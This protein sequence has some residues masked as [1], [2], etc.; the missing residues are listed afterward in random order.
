M[1]AP[2]ETLCTEDNQR[3]AA[4]KSSPEDVKA[5]FL[6]FLD[7]EPESEMVV[8]AAL[9]LRR[10]QFIA[11]VIGS[12]EFRDVTLL[13]L[14]SG[15]SRPVNADL[16]FALIKAWAA[17][18]PLSR[19]GTEAVGRAGSWHLLRWSVL[20]DP[21]FRAYLGE[22]GT[23]LEGLEG[24]EPPEPMMTSREEVGHV[25]LLLLGREPET[26][27]MA[28]S[29]L[30]AR[31][32]TF[33]STVLGSKEFDLAVLGP[34]LDGEPGR[35]PS[36][37]APSRALKAWTE[38]LPL[39]AETRD[40]VSG[41]ASWP[42]LRH[43]VFTD[44]VFQSA[45]DR[46]K[47]FLAG[48]ERVAPFQ[49]PVVSC[50]DVVAL[51]GLLLGRAPREGIAEAAEGEARWPFI[52]DM[53]NSKEFD[54]RVRDPMIARLPV[55]GPLFEAQ[56]SP[57]LASWAAGLAGS[58]QAR[59]SIAGA[60]GWFDLH[61]TLFAD[62]VFRARV[63]AAAAR[64][65]ALEG[66]LPPV[67]LASRDDVV[68]SYICLLGREPES[69]A[70]IVAAVG[71]ELIKILADKINS[72]EFEHRVRRPMLAGQAVSGVLFD[73]P[74]SVALKQWA[75]GLYVS[76][77]KAAAIETTQSWYQL[78]VA[79]LGD[80][81]FQSVVS[82]AASQLSGLAEALPPSSV[83]P[84]RKEIPENI[85]VSFPIT[86]RFWD[87][88][89]W[90]DREQPQVSIVILSY[91]RPDLA[92]NL[93]RSIWLFSAGYK[94]EVILVDNGSPAGE[95]RLSRDVEERTT[96]VRLNR[97]QYLGDAYNIG[98]ERAKAAFLVL[99]NND[100][101]VEPD[102][103]APL[104]G[105]LDTDQTVGAIGPKFLYPTGQLQ[106]AGALIDSSGY[107]VQ[108][109]KRGDPEAAEF[110][111]VREV[112][113][114]TGATIAMRRDDYLDLQGYDW[115][116]SPGYYEDVDL[117]FKLRARG[118]RIL[119]TP[120]SSVFHIESATMSERPPSA[121]LSIAV[122]N[123]RRRFV[124]KWRTLLEDGEASRLD[125]N[126]YGAGLARY[127]MVT[128]PSAGDRARVAVYFP[129][130]LIPGGG[131]K[132]ALSIVEQLAGAAEVY[133]VFE[134]EESVLRVISVLEDLGFPGLAFHAVTLKQAIAMPAFDMF[135][136]IGNELFP[137]RKALGKRNYF[138]CQF[139]FPVPHEFLSQQHALEYYKDYETYIVYSTYVRNR[140]LDRLHMWGV[141]ALVQ[142]LSPTTDLVG[143][144]EDKSNHITGVGRFFTGGHNKRHDVMIEVL[145]RIVDVAPE[146][147][148]KLHL[149]G[150]L[151][152][153][154]EHREHLK[155]LRERAEG[156]PVSFDLDVL[157]PDLEALYRVTKVYLHC[158]GWDV[159][160]TAHP[161]AAEHFGITV[162]EAMSAGCI[163]VVYATGGPAEIVKHGVNGFLVV[164]VHEMAEWTI[165]ILRGWET[166]AMQS[167]RAA[168][169]ETAKKYDKSAFRARM[170]EIG[171]TA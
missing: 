166:A 76:A 41:T 20:A 90:L 116:W 24:P 28:D 128:Q 35:V 4:Q 72:G 109:G 135:F 80:P 162:L 57:D 65:I 156:L 124:A 108:L 114:C 111:T 48:L 168:A 68:N 23:L 133:L 33:L 47:V 30:G 164:G 31:R 63:P 103:L 54:M 73:H 64:L 145:R 160:V 88:L 10:D 1:T 86:E 120:H 131:E 141:T 56:P 74:P 45:I 118:L 115:R 104:I 154:P 34:M 46:A 9:G 27:A 125:E 12:Q 112:H 11:S 92:E 163:P 70:V 29:A 106:E 117:C 40:A 161:E 78:H 8:T 130:E 132:F 42:V 137:V 85:R 100:I 122:D 62:P 16:P 169:Y 7:R 121:N 75:A 129:Y 50:E 158:G 69:E 38:T 165:K 67:L 6:L 113:Y 18:L 3:P 55:V 77:E 93:I 153:G 167:V 155:R 138:I 97:N 84:A 119:Y 2:D 14:L 101:V 139:P 142:V 37:R 13:P 134:F 44:P 15:H 58:R 171:I 52:A 157:R 96:V 144:V 127:R 32:D 59:D 147:Q 143:V 79:L 60:S 102:W 49:D 110:N 53:I 149:A 43:L 148:A 39:T 22:I 107:S 126:A 99:M 94:Y 21:M 150:A 66:V 5:T 151:H 61:A 170:R 19:D 82:R 105:P 51:Y 81:V 91:C 87:R 123:N 152:N 89:T 140:V 146:L 95:H 83:K 159:D 36:S 71:A 25:Y 136:L 17:G 26:S 98:V